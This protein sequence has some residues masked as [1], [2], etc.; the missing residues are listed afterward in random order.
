MNFRLLLMTAVYKVVLTSSFV[1]SGLLITLVE[2]QIHLTK[3]IK[4]INAVKTRVHLY[5]LIP[6]TF[7]SNFC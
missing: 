1:R 4:N 2:G 7:Y 5:V 3:K 6:S